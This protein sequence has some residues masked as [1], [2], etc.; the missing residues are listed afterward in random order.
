MKIRSDFV[1]NS[2]SCSFVINKLYLELAKNL[3]DSK[4]YN[5]SIPYDIDNDINIFIYAKNKNVVKLY[6]LLCKDD[7]KNIMLY[8]D[9]DP[10][11]LS[12]NP[13]EFSVGEFIELVHNDRKNVFDLIEQIEF[14]SN[15]YD[16]G[17][18]NLRDF[19]EFFDRNQCHPNA[20]NSEREFIDDARSEFKDVLKGIS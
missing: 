9:E 17:P 4:L 11:D 7:I 13:I 20:E 3:I 16:S 15:D 19:Y 2:S 14:V 10:N 6:K 12:W 5:L 8:K 18:M 1:S